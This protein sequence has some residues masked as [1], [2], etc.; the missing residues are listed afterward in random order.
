MTQPATLEDREARDLIATALDETLVVEAAAGTGKT[1][2]LVE[3]ILTVLAD[4]RAKVHEIVAVTFTEKAAGELKLLLRTGLEAARV[5]SSESVERARFDEALRHLEEAHVST[6]HGF[7]AELL[8]ERPVEAEV[9][10]IFIVLTEAQAERLYNDAFTG[11]I[12]QRL[13]NPPEGIR[14]SLRRSTRALGSETNDEHGPIDRLRR[15]GLALTAWRDF[16]APWRRGAFERDSEIESLFEQLHACAELTR[17][18]TYSGDNLYLDTAAAR[19]L[20]D[21]VG[22]ERSLG[23][24]DYDGW[25]ARLVDLARDGFRPRRKGSGPD[26]KRGVRRAA[27][28]AARDALIDSLETFERAVDADLAALLHDEL[29]G[30]IERYREL[31]ARAGALDYLDLL[32]KARDLL[33]NNRDVRRKLQGDFTRIFVDEFQDTDPLQAE[34]LLLLAADDEATS[35]W[36]AVIPRPGKLFIVGDP[37]QSIYRFR[38]ADVG[39]YQRVCDRLEEHGARR[40]RLRTSFRSTPAIQR[41]I[42]AAF[43][44][45]MDGDAVTLQPAYVP[46]AQWR[47]DVS[48]QPTLVALPVPE[49]YEQQRISAKTIQA[50]LADAVGAFIDWLIRESGWTVTERPSG[51]ARVPIQPRHICVLFRRF[52]SWATDITRPYV[53]A[54]EARGIP[55]VLVG[56]KAFHDREEVE[57]MRAA[58]A[59]IEWPDDELSIFATLRGGLFAIGDQELLEYRHRHARLHP[60]RIPADLPDRLVPI[61][62]ALATLREL[63]RSRNHRPV[64]E[65][66]GQVLGVTRAHV[67]LVLRR[68]GEQ[69]LA[70]VLHVAELARQ[71]ELGGGISFRGFVDELR[72]AAS[73][74]HAPEAPILEEGSDGVRLMTVHKAKGLEFPVVILADLTC[75]RCRREA[76]RHLDPQRRL[77]AIRIDSWSPLDLLDHEAE[78]HARDEAEALRLAYVAATRARDLLVVPG[79]GDKQWEGGWLDPLSDVIYPAVGQRRQGGRAAGCPAFRSKDSVLTR[80]SGDPATT[81]TVSPGRHDFGASRES[82]YSVVWWDPRALQLGVKRPFGLRRD[83][84]IVKNVDSAVVRAKT[85]AYEAW[86]HERGRVV[87]AA[88]QP[89]LVVK[90]ATEWVA[91][92]EPA[93]DRGLPLFAAEPSSA[94]RVITLAHDST[95]PAG[96]RYG[97]LVHAV[98][99]T[100]PLDADAEMLRSVAVLQGR[101]MGATDEE[102]ASAAW[103]AGA[104]LDHPLLGEARAAFA[105]G[106]CRREIPVSGLI[107]EALVEGTVDL[108]FRRVGGWTIVDFKTDRELEPGIDVYRKQVELYASLV[109]RATGEP[110]EAVLMRI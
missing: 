94:V 14:R 66:I 92:A 62:K 78:E 25:E 73:S 84:L 48:M 74:A 61:A 60:F 31:K 90:T 77:S 100:A 44:R 104:V 96:P 80:P 57:M 16:P 107:S 11:W 68:G 5:A 69:A 10:P 22:R 67:G 15:A 76:D 71:Y 4:D 95:R 97:T 53:D 20:S 17:N 12:P 41:A 83:D 37:K 28:V 55:H 56:G 51:D 65:T 50:S 26:Y 79:I 30:S 49:P 19:R 38:R 52:I 72:S 105:R 34:I 108:A 23:I 32:L 86:R 103:I 93:A 46:L 109:R 70:N 82:G 91:S 54:I 39:I 3:R 98:L 1:T 40:L 13:E 24:V 9:D 101:I 21:E 6:I 35:D 88:S 59:A 2:A 33:K 43:E 58:L 85:G 102:V 81:W 45:R 75:S 42:N 47:E 18:P 106:D 63:H 99:A 36:E 64:A 89:T 29:L 8:R 87:A 7:C 110:A 27:V